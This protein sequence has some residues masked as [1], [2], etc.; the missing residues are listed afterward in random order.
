LSLTDHISSQ[1][2]LSHT[3]QIT[4]YIC[5]YLFIVPHIAVYAFI[6]YC[7]LWSYDHNIE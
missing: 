2:V 4:K 3:A 6:M 7:V 1:A 5:I